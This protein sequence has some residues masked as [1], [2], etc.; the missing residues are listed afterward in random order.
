MSFYQLSIPDPY[1]GTGRLNSETGKKSNIIWIPVFHRNGTVLR[2]FYDALDTLLI[3]SFVSFQEGSKMS[4]LYYSHC[5]FPS[6]D[7]K[8]T[9]RFYTE[10]MGFRAVP[11]LDASEPHI[12]LYR[13]STEII[14]T[15]ANSD[16][17]FPTENCMDMVMMPIL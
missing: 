5:I 9:A 4:K 11:Y 12:C 10:K 7:I 14:L 1:P 8:K 3:N 16:K 6:P 13:D 17:V 2:Y 15:K